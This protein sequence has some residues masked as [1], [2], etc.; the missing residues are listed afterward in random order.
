MKT[1][2]TCGIY[3]GNGTDAELLKNSKYS[4]NFYPIILERKSIFFFIYVFFY[5]ILYI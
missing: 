1:S 2:A 5:T 4:H 3:D